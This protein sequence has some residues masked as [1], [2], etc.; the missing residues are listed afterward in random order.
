MSDKMRTVARIYQTHY[1]NIKITNA[2]YQL[3]IYYLLGMIVARRGVQRS[4]RSNQLFSNVF[5][6]SQL[7]SN[8]LTEIQTLVHV[9]SVNIV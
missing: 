3:L 2:N 4:S 6:D 8:D 1:Q 9:A 7:E 5:A